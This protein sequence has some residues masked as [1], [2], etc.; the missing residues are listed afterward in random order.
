MSIRASIDAAADRVLRWVR[1][2]S[3]VLQPALFGVL[4]IW[5]FALSRGALRVLP[6]TLP[7]LFILDR[8]LFWQLVL[9]VFF[10]APAGGFLG[11]LLYGLVSPLCNRLG[12]F[13]N[14]VKFTF[15]AWGYLVVLFFA[16]AP[17]MDRKETVSLNDP[18]D[19]WFIGVLGVGVGIVLALSTRKDVG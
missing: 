5:L 14:I 13:G 8:A 15:G 9:I 4:F 3:P 17:V 18:L 10:L 7:V 16:I 12:L 11:G 6:I 19:W 1:D 2:R